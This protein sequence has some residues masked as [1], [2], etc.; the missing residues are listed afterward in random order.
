[1]RAAPGERTA[2][3]G[4]TI[5]GVSRRFG[6][7]HAVDGVSLSIEPGAFVA[8]V[9]PSGCGKTTLLRMIGGL[10]RPD[11]GSIRR[12]EGASSFCF[13]EPRL[14]PWR[15]A[16]E[17]VALPLQLAGAP[18]RDAAREALRRVGLGDALER[19]PDQLSGGMRM[20]VALARTLVTRPRLVL[21]D[22]PFSSLDE[23]TRQELGEDLHA[24]WGEDRFTAVLV[25]HS[26]A[27][28]VFLA[29]T[30]VVFSPRPARVLHVE[31]I[32]LPR[33]DPEVRTSVAFNDH[34]R[35]ISAVLRGA[36]RPEVRS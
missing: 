12:T 34:V 11:A 21:L 26:I 30:C 16:L 8:L 28:A 35:R 15:S 25:T 9:G 17:N 5:D 32:D 6:A 19:R 10:D 7:V 4:I 36:M 29:T 24:L 33:H 3:I 20:R 1:M 27:E 31:P 13:Q 14:L 22:E 23:V 18:D 2:S